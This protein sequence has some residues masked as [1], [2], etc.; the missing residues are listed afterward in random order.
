MSFDKTYIDATSERRSPTKLN[1]DR[2]RKTALRGIY[3]ETTGGVRQVTLTLRDH[4]DIDR[5][6]PVAMQT[7]ASAAN[8]P[9][10]PSNAPGNKGTAATASGLATKPADVWAKA[11]RPLAE[12]KC[13]SKDYPGSVPPA[14]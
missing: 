11:T 2:R 8:L 10:A 9:G 6:H 7:P 3:T 12:S 14:K 4:S 1:N 5:A 13:E